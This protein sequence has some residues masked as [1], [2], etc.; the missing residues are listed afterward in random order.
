[1]SNRTQ[2]H[3]PAVDLDTAHHLPYAVQVAE[4]PAAQ[5]STH[6]AALAH[7]PAREHAEPELKTVTV[8][9]GRGIGALSNGRP[10]E[11]WAT[12][13]M[14]AYAFE[15]VYD[16]A[17]ISLTD[18]ENRVRSQLAAQGMQVRE[19]LNEDAPTAEC[20]S[21]RYHDGAVLTEHTGP[22]ITMPIPEGMEVRHHELLRADLFTDENFSSEPLVSFNSGGNGV[23]LDATGLD[24]VIT[25]LDGFVAGLR[26][27]RGRMAEVRNADTGTGVPLTAARRGGPE[28]MARYGCPGSWCDMDHAGADGNPGWHQGRTVAVTA[29]TSVFSNPARGERESVVLAARISQTT[30]DADV[31]GIETRI[32]LDVDSETLELNPRQA[33]TLF[34][35]L[36]R[37]LPDLDAMCDQAEQLAVGDHPGDPVLRAR[38]MAEL[39]AHIKAQDAGVPCGCGRCAERVGGAR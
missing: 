2:T 9:I 16:P 3:V 11:H 25:N 30:E 15:A 38:H 26:T 22:Q 17:Q 34:A 32:W 21:H 7:E 4:Q 18:A 24:E 37:I 33:R 5:T 20:I 28:W 10:T 35:G 19:F 39:D 23:L 36:R 14:D 8:M 27:M 31:F 1:M 29:P 12:P 6:P 13:D